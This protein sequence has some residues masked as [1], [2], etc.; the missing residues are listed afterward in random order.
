MSKGFALALAVVAAAVVV[1][2][3]LASSGT[4]YRQTPGP[5]PAQAAHIK[6]ATISNT[7][8]GVVTI[9]VSLANRNGG[10]KEGDLVTVGL[11]TDANRSTGGGAGIGY[12][13]E[14]EKQGG[15]VTVGVWKWSGGQYVK[16]DAATKALKVTYYGA[17]GNYFAMSFPRSRFGVGRTFKFWVQTLYGCTNKSGSCK[18][19]E[20]LPRTAKPGVL[21]YKLK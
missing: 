9:A 15:T 5:S 8:S 21:A 4:V 2:T 20:W 18:V 17:K 12:H 7:K 19:G 16:N 6:S 10:T 14:Y 11:D 3:A 13:L 1:G